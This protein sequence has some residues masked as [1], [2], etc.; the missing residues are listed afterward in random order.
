MYKFIGKAII[1]TIGLG[2]VLCGG[3]VLGI[4]ALAL[5]VGKNDELSES[6]VED[7]KEFYQ[8]TQES[9]KNKQEKKI[10]DF[11]EELKVKSQKTD[12]NFQQSTESTEQPQEPNKQSYKE[13]LESHML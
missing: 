10:N 8:K 1:S 6:L 11:L 12:K 7:C 2:T 9:K 5:T 3:I 4:G 13:W